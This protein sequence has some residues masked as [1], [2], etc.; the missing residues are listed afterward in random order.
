[1]IRPGGMKDYFLEM[2]KWDEMRETYG[3]EYLVMESPLQ[4]LRL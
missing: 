4:F 1:M 3:L 2:G